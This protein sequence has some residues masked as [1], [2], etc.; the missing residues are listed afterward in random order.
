MEFFNCRRKIFRT[1]HILLHVTLS[2]NVFPEL[3]ILLI[4]LLDFAVDRISLH[5]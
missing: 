4:Y 3:T 1:F 5:Q 2:Q